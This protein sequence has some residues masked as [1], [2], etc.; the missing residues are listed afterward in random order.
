MSNPPNKPSEDEPLNVKN[1]PIRLGKLMWSM[2]FGSSDD[3]KTSEEEEKKK[4]IET[5]GEESK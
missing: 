1:D 4:T 2:L 3:S 5:D